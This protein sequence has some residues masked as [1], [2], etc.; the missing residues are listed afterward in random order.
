MKKFLLSLIIIASSIEGFTQTNTFPATGNAGVGTTSPSKIFTI[1]SFGSDTTTLRLEAKNAP[2]AYFTEISNLHN[3]AEPF[4]IKVGS[5]KFLTLK[6]LGIGPTDGEQTSVFS[7]YSSL[8]LS[9]GSFTPTASSIRLFINNIGNVGIGTT[10]PTNKLSVFSSPPAYNSSV[11]PTTLFGGANPEFA[12]SDFGNAVGNNITLRLGSNNSTYYNYGAYIKAIQGAGVDQYKLEFGT[13]LSAVANTKMLIDY[14]GNVGIG[15][16]N[17][18]AKLEVY[19]NQAGSTNF[20]A[21]GNN[22]RLLVDY[23][24]LGQNYYDA[25]LH[26]FRDFAGSE[27]MRLDGST[28]N[29]GIGTPTPTQKLDINGTALLRNGNSAGGFANDQLLFGWNNTPNYLHAIKTR[30]HS[31]VASGNAIDFYTWKQGTDGGDKVGTQHV[32]TLDGQGF[33]GIGTTAPTQKLDVRG[34]AIF[35]ESTDL[36]SVILRNRKDNQFKNDFIIGGMNGYTYLGNYQNYPLGIYTGNVERMRISDTGNIGIGTSNPIEKLDVIGNASISGYLQVQKWN[37]GNVSLFKSVYD[38]NNTFKIETGNNYS[39]IGT[40]TPTPLVFISNNVEYGRITQTG[41]FGIGTYN[42][43][44][45][46][47]IASTTGSGLKLTG[48]SQSNVTGSTTRPLGVNGNGEVIALDGSVATQTDFLQNIKFINDISANKTAK[49]ISG[50]ANGGAIRF[51][52]NATKAENRDLDLGQMDNTGTFF[53]RMTVKTETGNVGIG[54]T[55]PRTKTEIA[56]TLSAPDALN[57]NVTKGNIFLTDGGNIGLVMGLMAE[58][59]GQYPSYLQARNN[60]GTNTLAYNLLLNPLGGNV[61]IGTTTPTAK[62]EVNGETIVTGGVAGQGAKIYRDG[63]LGGGVYG[64]V[65]GNTILQSTTGNLTFQ[66]GTDAGE[67]M[68]ILPNGNVGIGTT[69]PI[70]LLTIN[71][72]ID[73]KSG[74]TFSNLIDKSVSYVAD[75]VFPL[76]V[77]LSGE[78]VVNEAASL[79]NVWTATGTNISNTNG[80][81]VGIGTTTPAAKLEVS[82]DNSTGIRL[83]G[84]TSRLT[85]AGSKTNLWNI[86]NANGTMRFFRENYNATSSGTEGSVAMSISNSGNVGIGTDNPV[87]K[88]HVSGDTRIDGKL[89]IF[90]SINKIVGF[91]DPANYY[92][93]YYPVTGTAGLDIHWFGGIRLGDK[94]GNVLQVSEGNVGIGTTDTKGYKLAVAGDMIAE[95]VVVKLT[96]NWPDYVF[97]PNYKRSTLSE[98]E[99][100]INKNHHLPNIPSAQEVTDKGIDVGKMNAKLL[101]KMEEMTLYMIEQQ[102]EI[103]ALREEVKQIKDKK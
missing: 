30:H 71:S 16:T 28:G 79:S 34:N 8:G 39:T 19:G 72:K 6:A 4:N 58:A 46:L 84:N 1:R 33:V 18:A 29:V 103:K 57:A 54:T 38:E 20:R 100:Y 98:V 102:K 17:P 40:T 90:N 78:V 82:S 26:I 36:A 49:L 44:A 94:T 85:F 96:G 23:N 60:D 52:A 92:M 47:E 10:N 3:G 37:A 80:G 42:P 88:F 86:D 53:P 65:V 56:S 87:S 27:K 48:L 97:S 2:T 61:G 32:M 77:N 68:R 21:T 101:E 59:G 41:N 73:K 22:A 83:S 64:S 24:S 15:T 69:T 43:T 50:N 95:R 12:F 70:N 31:G 89:N 81:N 11:T 13:S 74:L 62:L 51:G 45:K 63:S 35:G 93:G 91:D 25:S 7:G 9:T 99:E 76:G 75:K 5:L 55:T 14:N 67:R 66:T